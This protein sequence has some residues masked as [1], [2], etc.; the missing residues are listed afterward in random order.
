MSDVTHCR[1][2]PTLGALEGTAEKVWGTRE[3]RFDLDEP[4]VFFGLYG[5]PD[6]YQ[7][8]RH[9]GKK[10]I[11]WCGTDITH[12][13]D[14]Y[15]LD[16]EGKIRIANATLAEWIDANCESWVEN[17]V[18]QEA[19]RGVGIHSAVCP[20]FL[21]DIHDFPVS[22]Q[23]S[24]PPEVYT[25]VSGDNFKLYGWDGIDEIALANPFIRFHL[26]G[27]TVP[28]ISHCSN[29]VVHGRVPKEQMN[30]E[31]QKMQ[32]ALRLAPFDGFSEILAKSVLMGQ[33]P[34]S[35]I[36]YPYMLSVSEIHLLKDKESPNIGGREYYLN[37]LNR[38][39][40]NKNI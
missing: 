34:V 8:W 9:R 17:D 21:G 40:W 1:W 33:Y 36:P 39:P 26:Y 38:F 25:S 5:L 29:V 23:W 22:Y 18:E 12:F 27:N 31:I 6:F 7:L 35:V 11:L 24:D 28:W 10:Y 16:K 32:G 19:L 20:S 15:W 37:H 4:C 13:L 2:S 30:R 3:Y 14:G